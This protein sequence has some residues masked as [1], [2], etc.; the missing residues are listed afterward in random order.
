[1]KYAKHLARMGETKNAYRILIEN[2]E[3]K[4]PLGTYRLSVAQPNIKIDREEML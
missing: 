1:M 4:E 3:G 2:P